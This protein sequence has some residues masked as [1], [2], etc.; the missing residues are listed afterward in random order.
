MTPPLWGLLA[1]VSWSAGSGAG[2]E[3][4]PPEI[5][6]TDITREA[7]IEFVHENG[8]RGEKLLPE[9]MGGG[10][11]ILDYDGDG[12]Q[13]LLLV[14]SAPWSAT[15][16]APTSKL[17]RN[18]GRNRFVDVTGPAEI[19]LSIYGQGVA[20]A[21]V[22]G[23]GW[24]DLFF[25]AVGKNR[26]L[27]NR[28]GV[29]R[30]VTEEA[31]VA[32]SDA[33]WSTCAAFFDFDG[34]GALDLFVCNY[35]RWSP[36]ID[37]ELDYRIDG[38]GRAYAPPA[39]LG[40]VQP[41]LYRNRGDGNFQEVS[42]RTGVLVTEHGTR[43][44][45]PKA[46]G[47]IP[48][49]LD[50]DGHLDLVVAND[51]TRNLAFHNRGD[52]TFEETGQLF[53]LAL[54]PDGQTTGAM[55]IDVGMLEDG[56]GLDV[57]VGNYSEEVTSLYRAQGD[58]TFFADEALRAGLGPETRASL[59]FGLLLFDAD[60]DGRLDLLQVNGHV[61]P[62]IAAADPTQ[63]YLQPA[64]LF[65]NDGRGRMLELHGTRT[66][67][68]S[69]PI[70]GR[71]AAYADLEGDGDLDLILTQTGDSPL[72]LRNDQRL[73]HHWLRVRLVGPARNPDALGAVVEL[74]DP[75]GSQWRQVMPTRSYLS[76]VELPVTFGV[77][78]DTDPRFLRV[79]RAERRDQ[80]FVDLP[81]DRSYVI[82]S[83]SPGTASDRA[84]ESR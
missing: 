11:A 31:A 62:E 73:S 48:V 71:G 79:V 47:V 61:E 80:R 42:A 3:A 6:F 24:R 27:R 60:L 17:Y 37:R 67:S 44:P 66:G 43:R 77:G 78:D 15:E 57:L 12:D 54:G 25:T 51:T 68:L 34:D 26:L 56:G 36:E 30:D 33:S 74:R 83:R 39:L 58:S 4:T 23:D 7:G 41:Y 59:T 9:T 29:F 50:S 2:A 53:G 63:S 69:R 8:A 14:N 32:G 72:L 35:L 28:R 18:E 19:D 16:P 5:P 1:L 55:G 20:V 46:L 84:R 76:Q 52:G 40:G 75:R 81:V 10:V 70:A 21:D 65:W 38:V 13:D 82:G 64:Q 49:D 45:V 22:D